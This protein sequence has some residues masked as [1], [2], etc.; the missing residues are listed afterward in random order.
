MQMHLNTKHEQRI[1][2]SN[3]N[4]KLNISYRADHEVIYGYIANSIQYQR[5]FCPG[6]M[7]RTKSLKSASRDQLQIRGL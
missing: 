7:H 4:P 3:K 2:H 6:V 1:E 5:T